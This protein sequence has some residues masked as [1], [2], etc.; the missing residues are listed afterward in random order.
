VP[1]NLAEADGLLLSPGVAAIED[2]LH[3]LP[4]LGAAESDCTGADAS[5]SASARFTSRKCHHF[6]MVEDKGFLPLLRL[7]R[8]RGR[9]PDAR[10][11]VDNIDFRTAVAKIAGGLGEKIPDVARVGAV[12][13]TNRSAI[14]RSE[15]ASW[16]GDCGTRR[17]IRAERQSKRIWSTAV[18]RVVCVK[19]S[20]LVMVRVRWVIQVTRGLEALIAKADALSHAT[21]P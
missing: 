15:P 18:S 21:M 14:L 2:A 7:W 4:K 19:F 8:S 6:Y 9:I 10:M 12:S 3:S 11:L 1:L 16:L 20:K 13:N 17:A 5:L